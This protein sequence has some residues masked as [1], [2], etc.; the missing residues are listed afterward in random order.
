MARFLR[1]VDI[2]PG[3]GRGLSI[4]WT[5]EVVA[6]P[7]RLDESAIAHEIERFHEA[8]N[9]TR[10]GLLDLKKR[11]QSTWVKSHA[12]LIE[13]Q[14]Q[15]ISDPS[16]INRITSLIR[17]NKINVEWALELVLRELT[18]QFAQIT[19]PYL[20]ERIGDVQDVIR[21]LQTVLA[22]G[23]HEFLKEMEGPVILVGQD[24]APS[25]LLEWLNKTRVRGIVL[26]S[27]SL[28]SHV[29]IMAR[30]IGI[31]TVGGIHDVLETIRS[32]IEILVDGYEGTVILEPSPLQ[33]REY[34]S[35]RKYFTEHLQ[36][37]TQS[38]KGP[39]TT[40]DGFRVRLMANLEGIY[41]ADAAV[42]YRA[43]GV[44]L[45]RSEYIYLRSPGSLPKEEDH[46][47]WYKELTQRFPKKPV[48]IRLADIGADKIPTVSTYPKVLNPALGLRAIRL[49]MRKRE[50]L[51]PQIRAILRV[52]SNS[53]VRLLLPFVSAIEE[54]LE[55]KEIIQENCDILEKRGDNYRPD[56]PIGIMVEIPSMAMMIP[57]IAPLIQFV[58]LGT[59]DL[60]Q[61]TL[62]VDRG[63]EYLRY[64]YKPFN[65]PVLRL[66]ANCVRQSLEHGI[67]V[68]VC[69]EMATDIPSV[70]LLV[71]MGCPELSMV[72]QWIPA[73]HYLISLLDQ[74]EVAALTDEML[75]LSSGKEIEERVFE[76][77]QS[78]YPE[79]IFHG[80]LPRGR[81]S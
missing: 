75:S 18:Q 27:S 14:I 34:E 24:L 31:P 43:E 2:A 60:I 68:S 33:I 52:A 17:E 39:A 77:I 10:D 8:L 15:L 80:I 29:A 74:K 38:I 69:G 32:G 65:P 47:K 50:I 6:V 62:A 54:I 1:G 53:H 11:L 79:G 13:A 25:Q 49:S 44:G 20:S 28:T 66:I 4:L 71:G 56:V 58:S 63:Y 36:A 51:D 7:L 46:Y 64:L 48:T 5:S 3:V 70:A 41:D 23:G 55:I 59:N 45:L 37:L 67:S 16:L 81:N 30:A 57:E 9:E 73:I 42:R 40:R 21:R 26:E 35:K 22:G 76:W 12:L 19:D 78:R 61:F 72:P